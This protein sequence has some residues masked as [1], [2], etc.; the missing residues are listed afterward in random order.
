MWLCEKNVLVGKKLK[1][2]KVKEYQIC[3]FLSSVLEKYIYTHTHTPEEGTG[4]ENSK[5]NTVDIWGIWV[6][7]IWEFYFNF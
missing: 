3:N 6:K 1:W 7:S 5:A 2:F 4:R